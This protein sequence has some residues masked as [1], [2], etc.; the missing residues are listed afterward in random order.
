MTES[1]TGIACQFHRVRG[2]SVS[3]VSAPA[4]TRFDK[5]LELDYSLLTHPRNLC[6]VD[7]QLSPL[8]SAVTKLC[9]L[10]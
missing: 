2:V 9:P 5:L 1:M 7:Q 4:L 3:R 8:Y 10:R 6:Q